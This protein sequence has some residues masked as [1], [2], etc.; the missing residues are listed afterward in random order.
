MFTILTN[1]FFMAMSDPPTWT[2]YLEYTFTGIYTFESAI[3]IFARGFCLVPFTF[4]RDPW[5]WLDFTVIV[6][7]Y[8]TE[9]VDLGNVSALRTFRVLRALK[10]ISVIPGLKTI[11]GA[12]IQSVR[13]LADVMILT[14]FCLSVFALIALQLFMGLL[15]Q[16]CVRSLDHCINSSYSPN[17]TFICHNRT[18]SSPADFL[19]N[20]DNF[21]KVE[22]QKDAL[23]CGYG[24]DAGAKK[25]KIQ[26]EQERSK[27]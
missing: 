1:C 10:T 8:V 13:K 5:N 16:K 26:G 2:K 3:K 19:S 9:F 24:S 22:G 17:T 25:Q 21:Y 11:V 6:M 23:I 27:N 4:L 14:V 18:W 12:L 15:R 20:E 7:A